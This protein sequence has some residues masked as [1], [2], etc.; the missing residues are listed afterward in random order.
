MENKHH[1]ILCMAYVVNI[2]QKPKSIME[3][4]LNL[5]KQ[6]LVLKWRHRLS[7]F[8]IHQYIILNSYIIQYTIVIGLKIIISFHLKIN[9]F[10][11]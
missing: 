6:Q 2:K 1:I 10:I 7:E 4:K 5:Q 11:N 8:G 9:V 3:I